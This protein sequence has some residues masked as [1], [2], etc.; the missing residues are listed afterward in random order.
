MTVRFVD[1]DVPKGPPMRPDFQG[2]SAALTHS[3]SLARQFVRESNDLNALVEPWRE[4]LAASL[5]PE[6]S[7]SPDWL[8]PWWRIYGQGLSLCVGTYRAAGQL[9][10]LAPMCGRTHRYRPGI[11]FQ[12]IEPLGADVDGSDSV[13]S[14]YLHLVVRPGHEEAVCKAF[15]EDMIAGVY[16]R[17][18]EWVLPS[19][20]GSHP[21]TSPLIEAWRNAGHSVVVSP[22]NVCPYLTLPSRWDAFLAGLSKSRR[23]GFITAQNDFDK[24]TEG[25]AVIHRAVDADTLAEGKRVLHDL[26]RQ[27]WQADGSNGV[28]AAPRF[29]AFHDDFMARILKSDQLELRWLTLDGRPISAF[30]GFRQG[31]KL[32]YYQAGRD[33]D[34]PN[35]V[36]LGIVILLGVIKDAIAAGLH[37]FDF[38]AGQAQYKTLFTET[39]RPLVDLRVARPT[40]REGVRRALKWSVHIARDLKVRLTKTPNPPR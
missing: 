23:R 5:R 1:A 31:S 4:L 40:L 24:W 37:E 27:R 6:L 33:I 11:P 14:D 10:G 15:V 28:F 12:R 19:V 18:D 21:L 7:L 39:T 16:G 30:Y 13:C 9:V 2:N 29:V 3:T 38:L 17:W 26:H 35:K 32:Y 8:V 34:V 22:R 20:D 36:R 25:R